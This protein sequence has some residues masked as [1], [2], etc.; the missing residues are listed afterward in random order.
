MFAKSNKKLNV[1]SMA[2]ILRSR[3]WVDFRREYLFDNDNKANR[4]NEASCIYTIKAVDCFVW[5]WYTYINK[6]QIG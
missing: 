4:A 6:I 3:G 1:D 5:M 2:Y